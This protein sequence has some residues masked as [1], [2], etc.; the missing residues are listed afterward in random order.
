[1]GWLTIISGGGTAAIG[2]FVDVQS[3]LI[4][5]GGAFG[6]VLASMSLQDFIGGLK[7]FTLIFKA[8]SLNTSSMIQMIID[9]SYVA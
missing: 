2:N 3:V 6:A 1:M 4:T 9:L 7:S 8:P 5:L